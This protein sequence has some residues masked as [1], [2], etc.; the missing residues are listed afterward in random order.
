MNAS[1]KFRRLSICVSLPVLLKVAVPQLV[2]AIAA[3]QRK[4]FR[5]IRFIAVFRFIRGGS[6]GVDLAPSCL[7]VSRL[8][9]LVVWRLHQ[10]ATERR[11]H[12]RTQARNPRLQLRLRF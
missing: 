12:S 5:K 2:M 3:A 11:T 9:G 8:E 7:G 4:T 6:L 1:S 10:K